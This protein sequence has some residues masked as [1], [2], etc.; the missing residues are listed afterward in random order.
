MEDGD[1]PFDINDLIL[2]LQQDTYV[3]YAFYT[4]YN[5]NIDTEVMNWEE[6]VNDN[7]KPY[8]QQ[9]LANGKIDSFLKDTYN[10]GS[11]K[12]ITN[13]ICSKIT[14]ASI[15]VSDLS[16]NKANIYCDGKWLNPSQTKEK[17]EELIVLY[18]EGLSKLHHI[19]I[20]C[21]DIY[22]VNMTGETYSKY[23]NNTFQGN[24]KSKVFKSILTYYS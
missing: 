17:L 13:K 11:V 6:Y 4:R 14:E 20:T 3:D 12:S 7:L 2:H 18:Q 10:E 1:K 23:L 15:K 5:D 8:I 16:R 21:C 22:S 9:Q 19:Y 24:I